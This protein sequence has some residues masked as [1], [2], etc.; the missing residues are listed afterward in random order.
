VTVGK[1]MFCIFWFSIVNNTP[2]S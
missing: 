2:S 1:T